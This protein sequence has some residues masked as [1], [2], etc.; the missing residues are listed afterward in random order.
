MCCSGAGES[1]LSSFGGE[2]ACS[3]ASEFG[4]K[5]ACS[6]GSF[7]EWEEGPEELLVGLDADAL[8]LARR[9]EFLDAFLFLT[10]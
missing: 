6:D 1:Q 10:I 3:D 8:R 4:C 2:K 9:R 7:L 5:K